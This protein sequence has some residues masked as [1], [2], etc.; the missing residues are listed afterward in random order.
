[1]EIRAAAVA[2]EAGTARFFRHQEFSTDTQ[3]SEATTMVSGNN[4]VDYGATAFEVA[5]VNLPDVLENTI[6]ETG[7]VAVLKL[8]VEG[9][10]LDI[11]EEMLRRDLF[12]NIR[13]SL[14]ETHEKQFPEL[15]ERTIALKAQVAARYPEHK[16][17]TEWL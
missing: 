13:I 1:M 8:D 6:R 5:M 17:C 7:E 15:A 10:E 4:N 9:A 14:I 2:N 12:D 11:V 16:V 3:R